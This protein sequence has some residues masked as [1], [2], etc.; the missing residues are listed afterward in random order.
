M[1]IDK[2]RPT[3]VEKQ[4][5][6]LLLHL[7]K[8]Q[9]DRDDEFDAYCE[10]TWL[11]PECFTRIEPFKEYR[12]DPMI[13]REFDGL[14]VGWSSDDPVHTTVWDKE[15]YPFIDNVFQL[16]EN[17]IEYA[18]P[19]LA[20]CQ[21][22]HFAAQLLGEKVYLDHKQREVDGTVKLFLTDEWRNDE[23]FGLLPSSFLAVCVHKK[24]ILRLP[25]DC[26]HLLRSDRCVYHGFKIK[27]TPFYAVQ[28]HPELSSVYVE[29]W[30][31]DFQYRKK[32]YETIE[33]A[34]DFVD[35]LGKTPY[36]NQLMRLFVEYIVLPYSEQKHGTL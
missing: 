5:R 12:F 30:L 18:I 1:Y 22:F 23:L 36:A 29:R 13:I 9:L 14:F 10:Y 28:S 16:L 8:E 26:I 32:Y 3:M 11:S 24:S 2:T 4:P 17:A 35:T 33:D 19:T 25:P 20:S 15:T 21:W 34:Q 6:V 31:M 7:R 27:H